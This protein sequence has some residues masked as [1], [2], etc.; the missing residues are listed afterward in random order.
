[1]LRL[2]VYFA[3]WV[4]LAWYFRSRSIRQ[5]ADGDVRWSRAMERMSAPGMIALGV[6]IT[7]AA[8]DLLMSLNPHWSSTIIGVYFF[9]GSVLAGLV[10]LTL[11]GPLAPGL[12]TARGR[13]HRRNTTTTW[14]S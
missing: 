14:A 10:V 13:G 7:L 8:V 6:T 5:D 11:A 4:F 1:M 3:V 12:R 9:S 2:A